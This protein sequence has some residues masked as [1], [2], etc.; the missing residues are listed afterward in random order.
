MVQIMAE[1]NL[2]WNT[3]PAVIN[4]TVA[5]V[6]EFLDKE[7]TNSEWPTSDKSVQCLFGNQTAFT[8]AKTKGVGRRIILKFLGG[9]WKAWMIQYVRQSVTSQSPACSCVQSFG[10]FCCF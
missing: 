8:E 7:L 3:S 10:T 2:D 6:K 1:E 9:N 4:Q 5:T